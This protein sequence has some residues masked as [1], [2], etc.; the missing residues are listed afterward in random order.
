[1]GRSAARNHAIKNST[2]DWLFFLDA[3]DLM[4]PK[5]MQHFTEFRNYDA[6]WGAI[7]EEH[8]GC[9]LERYQMPEIKSIDVLLDVDPFYTLQMGFF[10]KRHCMP[11]FDE[12]MNTG[13]DWK[14]YLEIWSKHKC[15]KQSLPFMI[16][17]RDRHSVGTRSATGREWMTAVSGLIEAEKRARAIRLSA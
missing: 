15:R 16:N 10:I 11:L 8:E 9:F 4:H 14:A 5:A 17:R 2:A 1:M 6:V 7:L 12:D 3:D 13:E